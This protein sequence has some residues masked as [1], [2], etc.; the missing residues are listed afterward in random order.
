MQT[1]IGEQFSNI[2]KQRNEYLVDLKMRT[3]T[4]VFGY[5]CS[6]TP[7]ELIRAAGIHP[8][9]L[10]GGTEDI[11]QADTLV[12]SFVCPFVRGVLDTALKGGFDYLDGIVHA[13]TCDATCG[14][15]GIWQRNIKTEFTYMFAPPYSLSEGALRYYVNELNKLKKALEEYVSAPISDES[16]SRSIETHNR[17]R[18]A[19]SRLYSVRAANP[20]PIAG[21]D[22]LDAVL[23]GA[24]MPP[25]EHSQM[26]EALIGEILRPVGCGQ[27][28]H[29]VFI[30]GSE[31][32][33]SEILRVI[34]EAGATIVGDDLCTGARGFS[35]LV[36]GDGGPLERLAR[37]Y[38]GRV[39]C[40]SRLP[41]R[42]RLEFI[43]ERM[44]ESR[45]QAVIFIIQ[46][47]CDPHLAEHPLLSD[48]L[49]GAG[50]P[51][52]VIET[53][54]RV[55]ANREQIRTRVQGFLEMLGVGTSGAP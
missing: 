20:S 18:A 5:F 45:A 38:L 2:V 31:L 53:E 7:V 26:T 37:R 13:Y 11:T 54:H 12:Q 43:L 24:I 9:R 48:V 34:E 39:P 51:N 19:L 1:A 23:C 28:A 17:Q 33:D 41:F 27:D 46:K 47:F 32:H 25:E 44:R 36:E 15:F 49:K 30:S 14:L 52:M 8:V 35:G 55:G 42:R 6:Y 4:K 3:G 16:I 29:R 50:I 21:S 10:F 22:V 40:P